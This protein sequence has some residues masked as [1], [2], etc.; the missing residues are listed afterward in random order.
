MAG[1]ELDRPELDP[2]NDPLWQRLETCD[3]DDIDA[4][5]KFSDRLARENGWKP[6]YARRVIEEYKRFCYLAVRTG[7]DVTPSDAV[8]QAWHLHL[9]YSRNY[10][11]AFCAT[12]LQT[13]LHHDPTQGGE[14]EAAK[15]RDWYRATLESYE[16]LSG[17]K[18]PEDIWPPPLVRFGNVDAMRRVNVADHF[19]IPKP[20]RAMLWV[21]QVATIFVLFICIWK[22][23]IL[24]AVAV[25]ALGVAIYIYRGRVDNRTR[26]RRRDADDGGR[27]GFGAGCGGI[28]GDG[29]GGGCGGC[30]GG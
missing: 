5:F 7:H 30:G 22:G 29:G 18:P 24:W 17:E 21:A 20:S 12:I 19:V 25:A 23:A 2:S 27:G 28:G 11:D 14:A 13:D 16:Q 4:A 15:Y 10:W 3:L 1:T 9:S 6:D 26:L 8:D